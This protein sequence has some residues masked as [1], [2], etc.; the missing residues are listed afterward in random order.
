MEIVFWEVEIVD[1]TLLQHCYQLKMAGREVWV[2][3]IYLT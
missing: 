3:V 1:I 2:N